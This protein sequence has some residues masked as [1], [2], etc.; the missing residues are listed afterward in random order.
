MGVERNHDPPPHKA[1][2]K[3]SCGARIKSAMKIVNSVPPTSKCSQWSVQK[4]GGLPFEQ[5]TIRHLDAGC[6]PTSLDPVGASI[7]P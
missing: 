4:K 1:P 2:K 6:D 5:E 3:E 7:H